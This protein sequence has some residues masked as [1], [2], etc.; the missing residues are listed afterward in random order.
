MVMSEYGGQGLNRNARGSWLISDVCRHS[1]KRGAG[2]SYGTKREKCYASFQSTWGVNL[3][4][5]PG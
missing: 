4:L 3:T 2:A 5:G 1:V